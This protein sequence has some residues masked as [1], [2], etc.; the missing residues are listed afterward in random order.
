MN[1]SF[2]VV[3][4]KH[5]HSNQNIS[6]YKPFQHSDDKVSGGMHFEY[7]NP[8]SMHGPKCSP[9]A[10]VMIANTINDGHEKGEQTCANMNPRRYPDTFFHTF[11]ESLDRHPLQRT[12][13]RQTSLALR[14]EMR[15]NTVVKNNR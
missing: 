9:G 6:I 1:V 8:L 10:V 5:T 4:F 14:E 13:V 11:L 15:H 2:Y 7:E 3:I 12:L